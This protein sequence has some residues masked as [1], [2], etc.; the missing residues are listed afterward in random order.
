[1]SEPAVNL[2]QEM[3]NK[4][5]AIVDEAH[6]ILVTDNDS[7]EKANQFNLDIRQAIKD[8][9]DW[10]D[11]MV[12]KAHEAHRSLTA[13]RSET[14]KPL[15]DASA[16]VTKQV[17]LYLAECRRKEE[18]EAE[19]LREIARKQAEEEQLA[20]ALDAEQSGNADEAN[21][22]L[23]T[24]PVYVA[25]V[26]VVDRP[27]VDGRLY[28]TTIKVKVVNRMAFLSNVK[29]E[30]LLEC[31]TEQA[32]QGIEAGLARKAKALGKAFKVAGCQVQEI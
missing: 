18:E 30:T 27:K 5:L 32:W 25:P 12:K 17:K 7:M 24:A 23:E 13:K 20:R 28:K 14:L 21:E 8:I 29:P 26:P 22:I 9:N 10:F 16:H 2:N 1:M 31:L 19:R 15:E 3:E 11:P 4:A 6:L